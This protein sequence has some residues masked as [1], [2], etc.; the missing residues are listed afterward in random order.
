MGL[1]IKQ[2]FVNLDADESIFFSKELEAVKAKSF[3]VLYPEYKAT[4]VIP[5]SGDVDP[6]AETIKYEQ[7][8][9]VGQATMLA[10][11][12]Q[13]IQRADVKGKEFR[14]PVKGMASS[15]GYSV[16]EIRAAKMAGKPLEQKKANAARRAI[17]IL[18]NSIAFFGDSSLGLNGFIN[19]PNIGEYTVPDGASTDPEWT[20]KTADEILADMNGL[21]EKVVTNSKGVHSPD[22]MLLPLSRYGLVS[23]KRIP[24]TNVTVLKFFMETNPHIKS[25]DW[26]NE[27][28]T[29]GAGNSKRAMV[30]KKDK[31]H[32]SLEIPQ[33][34]EQFPPQEKGLEYIVNCHQRTGGVI[35]PYPLSI[36]F[37]DNV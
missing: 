13:D 30:Y 22:S 34:F 29:A 18:Q 9:E 11:Y 35:C 36:A 21:A 14:V 37:G 27:L 26:L 20:T 17:E 12:S 5:V 1:R 7:Y 19:H 10:S 28:E 31:D 2:N 23:T 4:K 32:V 16:Q 6:G 8:D 24:D 3:D 33:P 25:V 15:Y